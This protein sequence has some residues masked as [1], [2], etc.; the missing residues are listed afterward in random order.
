[1][2]TNGSVIDLNTEDKI[3]KKL[4]LK[5]EASYAFSDLS[6]A[7]GPMVDL[8][9][10]SAFFGPAGVTVIGYTSPLIMLYELV[11]TGISSGARNRVSSLVGAGRLK[12]AN[13]VYCTSVILGTLTSVLMALLTAIFCTGVAQLLGAREAEILLMTKQYIY[14]YVIGIPFFSLTRIL[15]LYLEM[16]GQYTRANITSALTTVIDIAG[17]ALVVFVI[18]GGLFWIGLATSFGYILPF[19]VTAAYF[20]L[21]K[22]RIAFPLFPAGLQ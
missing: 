10:V 19:F 4:F 15:K 18:H 21:I 22:K 3:L 6:K 8:L 17:D 2:G 12:E 13:Q 1:M 11:G 7:I 5:G 14:G 20:Y 16:E 9:F